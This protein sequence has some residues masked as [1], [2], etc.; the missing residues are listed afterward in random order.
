M[1]IGLRVVESHR[2]ELINEIQEAVFERENFLTR[3][4]GHGLNLN[5]PKQMKT[6][7]YEDLASLQSGHGHEETA[8]PYHLR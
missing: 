4:I 6:F 5:S 8:R 3:V 7:F 1:Q 2:Q